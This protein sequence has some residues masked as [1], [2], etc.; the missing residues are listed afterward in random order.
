MSGDRAGMAGPAVMDAAQIYRAG[1]TDAE[2]DDLLGQRL[3]AA[4]GTLNEDGSIHLAYVIFVVEDGRLCFETASLTRK[5]RNAA[6]RGIATAMV[7][8]RAEGSGRSLMVSL[9]GTARVLEGDEARAVNH[10]IRQK[11]LVD[12]AV[13]T[14]DRAWDQ[15]DDVAIEITPVRRRTWVGDALHVATERATGLDYESLWR[16]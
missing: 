5:A 4:I 16:E 10:R 15:I 12:D 1:A 3:V 2:V 9:E 8:G 7:H 14:V 6:A 13:D 11:Y